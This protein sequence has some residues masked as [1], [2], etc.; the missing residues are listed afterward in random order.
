LI[1]GCAAVALWPETMDAYERFH[2]LLKRDFFPL[3]RAD[4]FKGSGTTFRRV[5]R[6]RIDILNVQGS[7]YGGKC[8]VNVA[9]HFLFLHKEGGKE[10]VDLKKLKE[11]ECRFRDRLCE[12]T[13][14]D[15]WWNYGDNEGE[16]QASV[17]NLVDLYRRR[18]HLFFGKFEPFPDVF[19]RITPEQIDAGN[20]TE[21]PFMGTVVRTALTMAQIMRHLGHQQKSREFAEVGLRHLGHAVG[22]KNELERLRDAA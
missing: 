18:G 19:E 1:T 10:I 9:T 6:D 5:H 3:L 15:L 22:L 13:K 20:L 4:G 14:E 8:C 2:D 7:R 11:Y 17:A 21:M 12:A 16:S